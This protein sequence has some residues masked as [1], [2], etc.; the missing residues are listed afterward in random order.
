MFLSEFGLKLGLSVKG[1]DVRETGLRSTEGR[2]NLLRE[3]KESE[4]ERA[5]GWKEVGGC[6]ADE[7]A[8]LGGI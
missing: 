1:R 8:S 3:K 4:K 6:L 5:F 2:S 7:E